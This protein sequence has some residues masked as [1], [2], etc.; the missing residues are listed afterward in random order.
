[1]GMRACAGLLDFQLVVLRSAILNYTDFVPRRE[2]RKDI[3]AVDLKSQHLVN[4]GC[5]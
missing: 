5:M 2:G 3:M 1:M 4:T